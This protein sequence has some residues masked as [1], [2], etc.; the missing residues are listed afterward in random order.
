MNHSKSVYLGRLCLYNFVYITIDASL[1][2]N[3]FSES[4]SLVD[5]F[6]NVRT[7]LHMTIKSFDSYCN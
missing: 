2:K 3:S 1:L 5:F 6:R 4:Y 7:Q